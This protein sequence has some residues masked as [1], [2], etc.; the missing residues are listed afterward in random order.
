M[1]DTFNFENFLDDLSKVRVPTQY[2][3]PKTREFW[4][5]DIISSLSWADKQLE[6]LLAYK[7]TDRQTEPAVRTYRQLQAKPFSLDQ[8]LNLD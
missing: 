6:C 1:A 8:G 4:I 2:S 7:H 5:Q 3:H